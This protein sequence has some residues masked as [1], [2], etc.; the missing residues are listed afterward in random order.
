M[1]RLLTLLIALMLALPAAASADNRL[2]IVSGEATF[3]SE[4]PGIGNEFV[5]EDSGTAEVRFAESKDP[6]G[7][8]APP[9]CRP[10]RTVQAPNNGG[11]VPVEVFCPKSQVNRG[12]TVDAGPAEDKVTYNVKDVP[13][14]TAGGTGTDAIDSLANSNDFLSGDQGND[15]V[16]GGN[17]NDELRGEDGNDTVTG[18]EGNDKVFAGSGADV[19]DAGNGD[20][21]VESND[22]IADKIAC[23]AG[24]DSVIADTVDEVAADCEA[25]DRKFVA[26]PADQPA[27]NDTTK[28]KLQAG[29][30]SSQRV[31]R[32]RRT[33]KV[34][35]TC[36][37]R[38]IVQAAGFLEAGGVNFRLKPASRQVSVAGG[39]VAVPIKLS[40]RQVKTALRDLRRGR[41]PDAR[42][43]VSC[44]DA[45]GNTSRARHFR[46]KLRK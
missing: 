22:G 6:Y 21:T 39:G 14:I 40:S 3:T 19:V 26:P 15:T 45:A 27:G 8:N 38:G 17:G 41:H 16:N 44:V 13:G 42:V 20:D 46:I 25:V 9:Q 1:T 11:P 35:A 23:G 32:K 33:V 2:T 28:P 7:I 10:G 34:L 36:S 5:V 43:T 24:N 30:S 31:T 18:G 12:I 4:D 29:G 37:E